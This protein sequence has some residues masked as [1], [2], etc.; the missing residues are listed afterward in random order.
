[1]DNVLLYA[2]PPVALLLFVVF[3]SMYTVRHETIVVVERFGKLLSVNPAGLYF[4]LPVADRIA[5]RYSLKQLQLDFRNTVYTSE[6]YFADVCVSLRYAVIP[7]RVEALYK[8]RSPVKQM[9][10]ILQSNVTVMA[11]RLSLEELDALKYELTEQLLVIMQNEMKPH[12]I[13]VEQLLITEVEPDF[14]VKKLLL[15]QNASVINK[16]VS[17]IEAAK[18]YELQIE[19]AKAEAEISVIKAKAAANQRKAL[20]NGYLEDLNSLTEI[21]LSIEKAAELLMLSGHSQNA[22]MEEV[23]KIVNAQ[24]DNSETPLTPVRV[25]KNPAYK[26]RENETQYDAKLHNV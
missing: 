21:G 4:K 3:V 2:I 14:Y 23:L 17:K 20:A 26:I 13:A 12:G 7:E 1:M 25:T 11:S 5:A 6:G 22:G 16:E 24:Y 10:A 9:N 8:M 18:V 15:K 19:R